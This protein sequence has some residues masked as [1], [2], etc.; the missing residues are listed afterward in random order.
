MS[1]LALSTIIYANFDDPRSKGISP[2]YLV[3]VDAT[4]DHW[5]L[6]NASKLPGPVIHSPEQSILGYF[7]RFFLRQL[8]LV[9]C[10]SLRL[11]SRDIS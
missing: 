6:S 3:G 9:K 2:C 10:I 8:L 1:Y 5:I 11:N 4:V 7:P